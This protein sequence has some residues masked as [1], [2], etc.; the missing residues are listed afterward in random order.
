MG[1]H[2]R[3]C[4]EEKPTSRLLNRRELGELAVGLPSFAP[5]FVWNVGEEQVFVLE[6]EV[7]TEEPWE[8]GEVL[9]RRND[10]QKD[11][12]PRHRLEDLLETGLELVQ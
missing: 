6:K 9:A 10:H 1:Q 12:K 5:E 7:P 2:S 4:W 3:H 11:R 8:E